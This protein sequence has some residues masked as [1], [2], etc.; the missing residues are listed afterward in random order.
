[1]RDAQPFYEQLITKLSKLDRKLTDMDAA[2]SA[3]NAS[4]SDGKIEV[5][6]KGAVQAYTDSVHDISTTLPVDLDVVTYTGGFIDIIAA[7]FP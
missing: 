3:R 1:M 6:L 2:I 7:V 4:L 5:K